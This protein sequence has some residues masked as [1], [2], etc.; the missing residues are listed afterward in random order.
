MSVQCEVCGEQ[1]VGYATWSE[2][3]VSLCEVHHREW[4]KYAIL[5]L[6]HVTWR[7]RSIEVQLEVYGNTGEVDAEYVERK[8][9]SKEW[10]GAAVDVSPNDASLCGLCW[11]QA[12]TRRQLLQ[13]MLRWT[14]RERKKWLAESDRYAAQ[15]RQINDAIA[16]RL[17]AAN[18]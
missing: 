10:V 11:A 6:R 7:L 8:D 17:G 5:N 1:A 18:D 4:D 14:K 15:K 13:T 3:P 12:D 16:K 9:G 2:Y